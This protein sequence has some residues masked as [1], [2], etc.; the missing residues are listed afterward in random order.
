M[1]MKPTT[2][3]CLLFLFIY[4][5]KYV[6]ISTPHYAGPWQQ[7]PERV[8]AAYNPAVSRKAIYQGN[9]LNS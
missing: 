9:E 4:L 8:F 5:C 2:H 6:E 3:S 1:T 7:A